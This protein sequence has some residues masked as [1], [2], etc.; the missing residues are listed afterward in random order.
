LKGKFPAIVT[1]KYGTAYTFDS[2]IEEGTWLLR[3]RVP[4]KHGFVGQVTCIESGKTL[5]LM[6]IHL[7]KEF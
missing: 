1:D 4:K 7:E 5:R 3:I 2:S 6:D